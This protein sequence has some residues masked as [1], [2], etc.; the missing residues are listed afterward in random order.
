VEGP[1]KW[2]AP[3]PV[4]ALGGPGYRLGTKSRLAM[5]LLASCH[6]GNVDFYFLSKVLASVV[7]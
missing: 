2:S 3:G 4:L 6:G 5:F 1:G 7:V